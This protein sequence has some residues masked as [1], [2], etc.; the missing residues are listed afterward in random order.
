MA[1]A[2]ATEQPGF[3]SP[4][5]KP[6]DAK[7]DDLV[8]RGLAD[9]GQHIKPLLLKKIKERARTTFFYIAIAVD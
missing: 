8:G 2:A 3:L 4:T 9:R 7:G 6:P 5:E 1:D